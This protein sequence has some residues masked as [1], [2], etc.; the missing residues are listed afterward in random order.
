MYRKCIAV[1]KML[2]VHKL[3]VRS[4]LTNLELLVN[5]QQ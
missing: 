2:I 3:S 4:G 5:E 1:C